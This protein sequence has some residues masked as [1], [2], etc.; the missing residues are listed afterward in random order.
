MNRKIKIINNSTN[1]VVF[2]T[3]ESFNTMLAIVKREE[4]LYQDYKKEEF[5]VHMEEVEEIYKDNHLIL[6]V[7]FN[8]IS[9]LKDG[10][11]NLKFKTN[12]VS[13]ENVLNLRR[14][15]NST[16]VLIYKSVDVVKDEDF[17]LLDKVEEKFEKNK[18]QSQRIYNVLFVN[19]KENQEGYEKFK[20]YYQFKTEKIIQHFKS[21]L[22]PVN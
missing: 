5:T 14:L 22:A 18:S 2:E 7:E 3:T 16:G 12:Q 9:F 19:W 11:V 13:D 8:P 1:E 6:P 4:G 20:D 10:G 15:Q 21:K 17:E